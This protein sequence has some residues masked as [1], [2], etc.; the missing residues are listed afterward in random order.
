MPSLSGG[1]PV[2]GT[3][4]QRGPNIVARANTMEPT[5]HDSSS[6]ELRRRGTNPQVGS[7]ESPALAK[8]SVSNSVPVALADQGNMSMNGSFAADRNRKPFTPVTLAQRSNQRT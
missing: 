8:S 4:V 3:P 6:M 1:T 7:R 2:K 5:S